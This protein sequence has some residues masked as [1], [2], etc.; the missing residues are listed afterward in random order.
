MPRSFFFRKPGAGGRRYRPDRPY[1]LIGPPDLRNYDVYGRLLPT[2]SEYKA[3]RRKILE[4]KR[5]QYVDWLER[6]E[7]GKAGR[8][9]LYLDPVK[10]GRYLSRLPRL[11]QEEIFGLDPWD[12][13]RDPAIKADNFIRKLETILMVPKK[14]VKTEGDPVKNPHLLLDAYVVT[15]NPNNPYTYRQILVDSLNDVSKYDLFTPLALS[16]VMDDMYMLYN[17]VLWTYPALKNPTAAYVD[18][19]YL[20]NIILRIIDNAIRK[21][22]EEEED[23]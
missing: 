13:H 2:R 8:S 20:L 15:I 1:L 22:R 16:H 14:S 9:A 23:D 12:Y 5:K 3:A 11:T 19:Q 6:Q 4:L 17:R 21:K 18:R 10:D 7:S